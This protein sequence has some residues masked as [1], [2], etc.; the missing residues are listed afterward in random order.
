MKH[1]LLRAKVFISCGQMRGS[2]EEETAQKIGERLY[3]LGYDPYIAVAEQTL[4]GIKENIF[5]QLETSEYFIFIDFKREKIMDKQDNVHRGSLFSHQEL[6]LASYLD[7]PLIAFQESGVKKEDGIMRFLQGNSI[8]FTDHHLLPDTIA[9]MLQKNGWGPHW[10]NQLQLERDPKQFS[11][12]DYINN[13]RTPGRFYHIKVCNRNY[14]KDAYNCY[15]YIESI[16][17]ILKNNYIP[18]E[19]VELKWAGYILPNA[20]IARQPGERHFDAF[21]VYYSNPKDIKFNLFSDS[22]KFYPK[23]EGPGKYEITYSV[24]AQNFPPARAT[25]S[26]NIGEKIEEILFE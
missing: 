5:T 14:Q 11:H 12:V 7:L 3:Q 8:E 10:K 24:I 23:I 25:F 1:N 20:V 18:V 17:D 13:Q 26:L 9:G 2:G 6:A 22:S 15:A 21:W 19:T 16:K 4:K